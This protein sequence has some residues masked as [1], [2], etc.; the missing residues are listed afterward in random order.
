MIYRSRTRDR[1]KL[2]KQEKVC[3]FSAQF[4]CYHLR[5]LTKGK[6]LK[7][8]SLKIVK[9]KVFLMHELIETLTAE[10]RGLTEDKS[11]INY[12]VIPLTSQPPTYMLKS[13]DFHAGKINSVPCFL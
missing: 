6:F 3:H 7:V 5:V 10:R 11:L 4:K 13:S 8:L 9:Y 2:T 12:R 1:A